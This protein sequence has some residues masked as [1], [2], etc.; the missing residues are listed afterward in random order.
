MAT[1]QEIIAKREELT[2]TNPNATNVDARNA[3]STTPV[4]NATS[5][6]TSTVAQPTPTP[7]PT[8]P[9]PS[10]VNVGDMMG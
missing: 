5:T 9:I 7:A 8:T 1:L 10:T 3:L 4:P 6:T 2:K